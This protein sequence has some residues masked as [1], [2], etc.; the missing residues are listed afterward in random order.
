MQK[1][2]FNYKF[3]SPEVEKLLELNLNQSWSLEKDLP[4]D[5]DVDSDRLV[6]LGIHSLIEELPEFKKLSV[7]QQKELKFKEV[8]FHVSN[9]LAGEHK[10]VSLACQVANESPDD[11]PDWRHFLSS[12][13]CDET[14]H[15][16]ALYRFL[17]DKVGLCYQPHDKIQEIFGQLENEKSPEIKLFVGQ[18][19]L[20]WTATSLLAS[21][22]FKKPSH[23]FNEIVKKILQDEGRHLAFSRLAFK[24]LTTGG[25]PGLNKPM[26][27][28]IFEAIVSCISSFVAIPVWDEYGFSQSSCREYAAKSMENKGIIKFYTKILPQEL[29]RC[30][31]YS[32]KLVKRIQDETMHRVISDHWSFQARVA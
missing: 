29:K 10:A 22:L 17:N 13:Q 31:L 16:L 2:S 15:F 23:L 3:K 12:L 30:D 9:V 18:V 11:V 32:E 6:D 7:K 25:H 5:D 14:R 1:G 26:E 24:H 20:E 19:V 27:E 4:W 8:I 28:L 21:L